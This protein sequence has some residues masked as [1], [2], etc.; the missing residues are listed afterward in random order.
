MGFPSPHNPHICGS[1]V[2]YYCREGGPFNGMG[3]AAGTQ[4]GPL[5]GS[6]L[7]PSRTPA[8]TGSAVEAAFRDRQ[9]SLHACARPGR[10]TIPWSGRCPNLREATRPRPFPPTSHSVEATAANLVP[11]HP[12]RPLSRE[13][14]PTS[15][16]RQSEQKE[17]HHGNCSSDAWR[18]AFFRRRVF[19]MHL[20]APSAKGGLSYSFN[21]DAT[22]SSSPLKPSQ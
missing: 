14:I 21:Y 13:A 8:G 7:F 6:F 4:K 19:P 3:K 22:D 5:P 12:S 11:N 15:P 10:P 1:A 2:K 20:F 9:E 17:G 18:F 16:S